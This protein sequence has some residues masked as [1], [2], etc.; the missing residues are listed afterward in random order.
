MGRIATAPDPAQGL[1]PA[2][3]ITVPGLARMVL[4]LV[5]MGSVLEGLGR[6]VAATAAAVVTAA[7]VAAGTSRRTVV[8]PA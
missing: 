5:R 8:S 4:G 6:A 7:A 1:A 3:E 2:A